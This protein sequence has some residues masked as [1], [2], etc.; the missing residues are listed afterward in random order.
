VEWREEEG[1]G[2]RRIKN[3][4]VMLTPRVTTKPL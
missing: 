2:R 3:L 4:E 1:R